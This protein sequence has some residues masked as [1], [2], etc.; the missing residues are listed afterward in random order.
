MK[1]DVRDAVTMLEQQHNEIRDALASLREHPTRDVFATLVR[2]LNVHESSEQI[3]IYPALRSAPSGDS[4]AE[5]RLTEEA[6]AKKQLAHLE[7]I[8][9]DDERFPAEIATFADDVLRHATN[10]E[11]SVFP[12][13]REHFGEQRLMD[14][15]QALTTAQSVAP[16]HA[17][18]FVPT[19]AVG[20]LIIGPFF[21]I[22]DRLR[23]AVRRM[24]HA[25]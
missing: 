2:L 20:N 17:H 21:S 7:S 24:R 23:D 14:M 11:R 4:L 3:V 25:S 19:N 9:V 16:T 15:A 12:V 22:V 6:E 1:T 10:E 13:L 18:R 8:G 5:A